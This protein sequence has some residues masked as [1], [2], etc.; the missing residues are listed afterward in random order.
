MTSP[1][2]MPDNNW[3]EDSIPDA[4]GGFV[5]PQPATV[6]D[7]HHYQRSVTATDTDTW[8][9]LRV[10]ESWEYQKLG[11]SA[12]DAAPYE[13]NS[14]TTIE[15]DNNGALGG[16]KSYTHTIHSIDLDP[17]Q[18]VYKTDYYQFTDGNVVTVH[19]DNSFQLSVT[20]LITAPGIG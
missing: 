4:F 10:D 19:K 16:M 1:G 6:A 17:G 15:F 18:S 5:D 14:G 9:R 12:H 11:S 20:V 13:I 2:A 8:R 7:D 3:I